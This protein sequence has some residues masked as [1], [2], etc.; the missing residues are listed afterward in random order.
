MQAL[1]P[2]RPPEDTD[3]DGMPDAWEEARELDDGDGSD[4]GKVM[5]SGY[6]AIEA[7]CQDLAAERLS[8]HETHRAGQGQA[9]PNANRPAERQ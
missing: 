4:H 5:Q 3:Q 1:Q 6:T 2:Q 9:M 8:L 7:Y